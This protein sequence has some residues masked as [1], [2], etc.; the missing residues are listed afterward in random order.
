MDR[1]LS[2]KGLLTFVSF[3]CELACLGRIDALKLVVGEPSRAD[4][5]FELVGRHLVRFHKSLLLIVIL[6]GDDS[7]TFLVRL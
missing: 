6:D 4:K 3:D 7:H 5:V 1:I 2:Q